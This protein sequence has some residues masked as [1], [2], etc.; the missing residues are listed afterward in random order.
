MPALLLLG[1]AL[2]VRL[3]T[4]REIART[5][6]LRPGSLWLIPVRDLLSFFT[7]LMS[8]WGSRVVWRQRR[9]R[10]AAGGRLVTEQRS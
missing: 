10:V 6:G 1:L 4:T 2:V 3:W 7:F 5:S 9:L 8:L